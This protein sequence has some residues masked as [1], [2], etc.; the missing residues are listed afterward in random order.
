MRDGLRNMLAGLMLGLV[1]AGAAKASGADYQVGSGDLLK[2]A[3]FGYADLSADVRVSQSGNITFPLIGQVAVL[4][5]PTRD[6]EK[7]ITLRLS[8]G[9]FVN[10]AQVSVQV[11]EF[12]SQKVAVMGQVTRPGQ[13]FLDGSTRLLDLLARAGGAVSES[14]ADRV[15]LLKRNG[16]RQEIDLTALLDGDAQQNPPVSDGDTINVPRAPRFY[17]Y[18]QVQ[19]PGDYRLERNMTVSRAISA[20]GG[21]TAKGS[22]RRTI[23]KRRDAAGKERS[24]SIKADEVLREDDILYVRESI[25]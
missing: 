19:R 14:A 15:V 18:G 7:L 10:G 1:L 5:L 23:V 8:E 3:A 22:E 20:S 25:F 9:G 4:G 21:L 12:Q 6:I 2:I 24:S 17:I 13:Y 16:A 11:A